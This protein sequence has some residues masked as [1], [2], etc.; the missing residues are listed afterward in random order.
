MVAN[1]GHL[2]EMDSKPCFWKS[3]FGMSQS[4]DFVNRAFYR[5]QDVFE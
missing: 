4:F 3:V 5:M 2:S 1:W